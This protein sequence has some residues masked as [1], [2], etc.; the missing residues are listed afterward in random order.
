MR[1]SIVGLLLFAL[2]V[3]SILL[4]INVKDETSLMSTSDRTLLRRAR[5]QLLVFVIAGGNKKQ[6]GYL[7]EYWKDQAR[8]L[9]RRGIYI[10]LMNQRP[11]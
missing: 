8:I 1:Y 5:T 9:A 11:V 6:Y 2:L 7:R 4:K 3:G 10:Y